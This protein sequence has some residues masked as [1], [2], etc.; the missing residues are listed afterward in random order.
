MVQRQQLH[1]F[2]VKDSFHFSLAWPLEVPRGL[3]ELVPVVASPFNQ[4]YFFITCALL[5]EAKA[6]MTTRRATDNLMMLK[7][8]MSS[9]Y[10][11]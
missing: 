1:A 3:V 4:L 9:E 2:H 7:L 6:T 11:V 5:L 8:G 10:E